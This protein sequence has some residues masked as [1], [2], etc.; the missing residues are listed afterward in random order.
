M[1]ILSSS[2]VYAA[3]SGNHTASNARLREDSGGVDSASTLNKS[4]ALEESSKDLTLGL[5]KNESTEAKEK[6]EGSGDKLS[7]EDDVKQVIAQL[8]SRDRE[9]R[10]HEAAH[11][12]AAGSYATSGASFSFQTGPDGHQYAVG[13]EVGIDTSAIANDPQATIVKALQIIR[14]A[15]APAD[16]SG[17]D[18]S[19]ASQAS[20]ML[21]SARQELAGSDTSSDVL[22]REEGQEQKNSEAGVVVGSELNNGGEKKGINLL[23]NQNRFNVRLSLQG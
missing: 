18:R 4:L 9:V 20:Q 11:L 7:E 6:P 22:E 12:A 3:L 1:N 23:S 8:K 5:K 16:P 17:Q 13:G 15:N 19:V 10:A 2:A 14:A 21:N